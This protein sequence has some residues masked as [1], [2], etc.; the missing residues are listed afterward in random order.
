MK[1][2]PL[3]KHLLKHLLYGSALLLASITATVHSA[4]PDTSI[5][6]SN[7]QFFSFASSQRLIVRYKKNTTQN[8]MSRL[9]NL[10]MQSLSQSIG[11]DMNYMRKLAT[12]AHLMRLQSSVSSVQLNAIMQNMMANPDIESVEVDRL[13]QALFTPNDTRYNE[14]WQYFEAIGGLNLPSAWDTTSGFD[15]VVA[16]IDT[17]YLPHE[18]LVANIL[19]GYDM[20]SDNSIAQDGDGR[21][22]DASD[23]GDWSPFG[24]C[25]FFSSSSNSSWHGTHV[26]GSIAAETNNGIGIAG[27]AFDAK[28]VPVRVLGR[29]GG[30]TSDIA[31]GIIWAAGGN[32]SGLPINAN[33]AQ[34]LNLSLG[35]SGN[36]GSTTQ[37]AIDTA[38]SL[39]ATVVVAAGNANQNASNSFPANCTGVIAVAATTRDGD[40]AFYSNFGSVVDVAAPGGRTSSG[41]E[42][43]ILSTLNSGS[44]SPSGD[45]YKHYQGTS[46]AAP[47]VAGV[48]AL[49]YSVDPTLTPSEVEQ[50]LVDTAR[51]FP[52]MCN[53]CGSGIV[54]AAAAVASLNI[55]PTQTPTPTII[56]TPTITPTITPTPTPTIT[57]TP[58]PPPNCDDVTTFN[59]YHESAGRATSTS[60]GA[61]WTRSYIY[62]ANGSGDSMPGSRWSNNTLRSS[63]GNYWEIGSCP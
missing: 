40:R 50:I 22:A 45:S 39:G 60:E 1:R 10:W 32:V 33:P 18:D 38:R 4:I 28:I 2:Q 16:V 34:V 6:A 56:P 52:G 25:G 44:K 11:T 58:T 51:S 29:C 55:T 62:T 63:N 24:G 19:P 54:D 15:T 12:G 30:Y 23:P 13:M 61:W 42:N 59:Y 36:C 17:G 57:P 9:S 5:Q 14:Q 20:I 3:H 47:H 46:M 37:N 35:G 53:E 31:E 7:S 21:D 41:A 8:R 48:A 49:L 27:V 43:G 26:A